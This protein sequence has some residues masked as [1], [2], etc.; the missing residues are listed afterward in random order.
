MKSTIKTTMSMALKLMCAIAVIASVAG[1]DAQAWAAPKAKKA[2]TTRVKKAIKHRKSKNDKKVTQ[3]TIVE[4]ERAV[5]T[6]NQEKCN[7][8][9]IVRETP[10]RET[11]EFPT[12]ME[13]N[14][15]VVEAPRE[16]TEALIEEPKKELP[17]DDKEEVFYSTHQM[18][19]FPG[20]DDA[21]M[22]YLE[23]NIHYPMSAKDNAIQGKVIVQFVVEK[24]GSI[25]EVKVARSVARDLDREAIRLCKSLPKFS[26]GRNANGEPVRV[27]YTLPV[28]FK[29]HG[30]K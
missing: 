8:L 23:K 1:A 5:G 27:W 25:G 16:K 13:K 17:R 7:E 30:L 9:N 11:P 28:T 21:L 10:I 20:G 12:Q 29:L 24:D 3:L 4:D 2:K 18:P 26:P 6:L 15:E 22:K 19:M 14:W